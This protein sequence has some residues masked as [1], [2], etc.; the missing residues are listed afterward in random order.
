MVIG[1]AMPVVLPALLGGDRPDFSTS[2]SVVLAAGAMTLGIGAVL[3]IV[4]L[5][6]GGVRHYAWS[7]L[8]PPTA[9]S[10]APSMVLL[11]F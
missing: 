3:L 1:S 7:T 2:R 4:S 6:N 8:P 5:S 11:R 9:A 10:G